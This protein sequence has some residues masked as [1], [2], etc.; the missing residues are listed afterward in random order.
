MCFISMHVP[1]ILYYFVLW[2]TNTQ[3]FHK[4]SQSYM[5]RHYRVIRRELVINILPSYTSISN[6][7]FYSKTNQ[8][9]Q[10]IKF[11]LFWNN[12]LHVSDG[13]SIHHQ[14]LQDST[15]SKRHLPLAVC[16]VLNSWWWTE[17]PPETCR[18]SF[19]N[20]IY[21]IHWCIYLVL[22]LN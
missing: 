19:Q 10:C 9:H 6:L 18:V 7:N 15:Y 5:F 3:L 12:T 20:K 4:L 14:Q 1:C 11:I 21:L 22:L 8:M 16:T 13:L 17:R 2:P